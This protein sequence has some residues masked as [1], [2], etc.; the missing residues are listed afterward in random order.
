[1]NKIFPPEIIHNSTQSHFVDNSTKSSIIYILVI[2]F[3]I[4]GFVLLPFI[5]VDITNQTRGIVRTQS[6]NTQ[7]Q[8]AVY[9]E[10]ETVNITENQNVKQGDVLLTLKTDKTDEQIAE[11]KR[12][13]VENSLFILDL[14]IL[15]KGNKKPVTP[16]YRSEYVQYQTKIEE[17]TIEL[18]LAKH[19]YSLKKQLFDKKVIPEMEYLQQKNSYDIAVS[20]FKLMKKQF[21]NGWQSELTRL[22]LV[23]KD[24]QS[25]VIQLQNDKRLYKITAPVS[26]VITNVV[27]VKKGSF[28]SPNQSVGQ[29]SPNEDLLVECYVSPSDIGFI[30]QEQKV[31]F[32]L[33]AFNYNQWG[34]AFGKVKEISTDIYTLN[35]QPYFK[36]RCNLNTKYLSLK[37]GYKG[38]IKKGMTLTARFYLTRR[39]LWQLLFDKVDDWMNPKLMTSL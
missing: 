25:A 3:I 20:R 4:I 26:G 29:I 32:Q 38:N 13:I 27:G 36:V 10:V 22:T 28:L 37:T 39:T 6:E 18:K 16:K 8:L 14:E 30:K 9:G 34:M 17:H 11:H 23:N 35:E 21:Q 15:I 12:D 24:L 5:S 1:M 31:R 2:V 7:L 19:E 33:D